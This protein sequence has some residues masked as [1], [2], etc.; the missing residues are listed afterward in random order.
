MKS[1]IPFMFGLAVGVMITWLVAYAHPR[2]EADR[3]GLAYIE[4]VEPDFSG[5]AIYALATIPLIEVGDTNA[6]I[7]RLSHPIATYYRLY[8]SDAGTNA[9]RAKMR[10]AIEQFARSNSVV[11]AS[12]EREMRREHE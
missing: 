11:A 10:D 3:R 7:E 5:A 6:A 9:H 2:R 4:R 1:V 12:I 8:A